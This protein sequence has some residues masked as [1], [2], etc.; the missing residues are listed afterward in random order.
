MNAALEQRTSLVTGGGGF[1]GRALVDALRARGDRVI[2]AE[3]FGQ[4]HRDDILFAK[5]DIRDTDALSAL[6]QGVT[7][8]FHNASL[9]HTKNNRLDDVWSVNLGGSRSVLR[10]AYDARVKKLV[11]VSTASAVYE[12]RDIEL[13]PFDPAAGLGHVTPLRCR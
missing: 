10:A 4:P 12:G 7:T 1:V 9:V 13:G 3:P 8:I 11:Y 5:V 6:C 2:V